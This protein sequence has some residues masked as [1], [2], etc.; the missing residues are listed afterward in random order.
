MFD[1]LLRYVL[2]A[3]QITVIEDR[4]EPQKVLESYTITF[5]YSGK[6][7]EANRRVRGVAVDFVDCQGDTRSVVKVT[8]DLELLVRNL[9]AMSASFPKL[10][11]MI[12]TFNSND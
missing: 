11:G 10:P 2:K 12:L 8:E 9:K 5:D 4:D 1:A 6:Q 3:V 7:G